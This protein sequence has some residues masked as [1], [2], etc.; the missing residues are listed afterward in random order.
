MVFRN[1]YQCHWSSPAVHSPA[2][3]CFFNQPSLQC[4][5]S[6]IA[7]LLRIRQHSIIPD[8]PTSVSVGRCIDMID[9][10]MDWYWSLT[11][12]LHWQTAN[13]CL[14]ECEPQW[15]EFI[16]QFSIMGVPYEKHNTVKSCKDL[17]ISMAPCVAVDFNHDDNTCKLHPTPDHLKADATLRCNETTQYRL[18]RTCTS[19]QQSV[20]SI[21]S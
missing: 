14:A 8:S 10:L 20:T 21:V 12:K 15:T 19:G 2:S 16:G 11:V 13:Y 4:L 1:S 17:C 9:Q 5:S 7:S 3:P 18:K 6:A